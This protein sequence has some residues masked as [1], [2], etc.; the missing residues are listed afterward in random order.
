MVVQQMTS[1]TVRLDLYLL[2]FN[3]FAPNVNVNPW[4]TKLCYCGLI[5][6]SEFHILVLDLATLPT[7]ASFMVFKVAIMV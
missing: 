2:F 4:F 6:W 7:K 5:I 1:L 3:L